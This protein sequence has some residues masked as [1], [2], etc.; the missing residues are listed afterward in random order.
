MHVVTVLAGI[1]SCFCLGYPSAAVLPIR[2]VMPDC[3]SNRSGPAI[4]ALVLAVPRPRRSCF[5]PS[6]RQDA[7]VQAVVLQMRKCAFPLLLAQ[8]Y[9]VAQTCWHAPTVLLLVQPYLRCVYSV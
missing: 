9:T 2:S 7:V 1:V 6:A 4:L 3:A 5:S 8:P